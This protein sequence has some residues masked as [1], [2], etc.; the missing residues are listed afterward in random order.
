MENNDFDFIK[1]K[2]DNDNITAPDSL[3]KNSIQ[4]MISDKEQVKLKFYKKKSF[5]TIVSIAACFAVVITALSVAKPFDKQNN[6][7]VEPR[8]M[9]NS[10]STFSSYSDLIKQVKKFEKEYYKNEYGVKETIEDVQIGNAQTDGAAGVNES[11]HSETQ[12]SYAQTNEQVSGVREGDI[13][14]NDGKYIYYANIYSPETYNISIY[15]GTKVISTITTTGTYVSEMYLYNNKLVVNVEKFNNKGT[16]GYT[17]IYDLSDIKSP[18]LENTFY[19]SG[20][21]VSTR[22]IGD[23]LYV[24]TNQYLDSFTCKTEKDYIPVLYNNGDTEEIKAT[25]ICCPE[26]P[27]GPST[28]II[29][30]INLKTEKRTSNTRA[31]FG[32]GTQLYCS[33]DNMYIA[34]DSR[35]ESQ[36]AQIQL[37][38]VS[39]SNESLDMLTCMVDGYCHNQFS[40]DEKDGY[41]RIAT[42]STDGSSSF[43]NNLFVFDSDLNK[44]GEITG[45]AKNETIKAVRFIGDTAYVITYK[46]IDP[47]FVIDLSS[48]TQPEILGEV[49]ITGF[50]SMLYPVDENTIL[51]VG[52]ETYTD[53]DREYADGL[54]LALFDISDKANP[55]VLD[56][57]VFNGYNS[58]AQNNH[59][60]LNFNAD[61]GYYL[62]D[63]N[64]YLYDENTSRCFNGAITFSIEDGKINVSN[65]YKLKA[66]DGYNCRATYIDDS[67]YVVDE[68]WNIKEFKY[69]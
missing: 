44:V 43:S 59:K 8:G 9:D 13:I 25:D 32:A 53:E 36:S 47:L 20:G 23:V 42:T 10:I 34:V 35:T 33:R 50:S 14:L 19:Q 46:N 24:V 26:N 40:M 1:N 6:E 48:P 64:A 41:L 66:Y 45:I 27:T 68:E 3:D 28:M 22:M 12:S 52:Y 57:K 58:N 37:F 18:K 11:A 21:F 62:M 51:G 7:T 30:A 65:E 38:K 61:K 56:S 16:D 63:Y 5:K 39:L 17:E 29:S 2:F 69:E 67:I 60:A 49:E 4:D 55:K 54:K 31:V 15:E